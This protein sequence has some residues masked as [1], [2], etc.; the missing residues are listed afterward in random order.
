MLK[1][2]YFFGI[3]HQEV[4]PLKEDVIKEN[5]MDGKITEETLAWCQGMKEWLPL[6]DVLELQEAFGSLLEECMKPPPLPKAAPQKPVPPPLPKRACCAEPASREQ[7]PPPPK[8]DAP[9]GDEPEGLCPLDA[10][11]YRFVMWGFRPWRGKP[12]FVQDYVRKNPRRAVWVAG[13]SI[14]SLVLMFGLT[15]MVITTAVEDGNMP[16]QQQAYPQQSEPAQ[17]GGDWRQRYQIWQDQQR[18]TQRIL[19]DS[20]RYRRDSQDRRDETYRRANYDWY[21]DRND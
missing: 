10:A 6:C 2:R 16:V 19:D 17:G 21:T 3:D 20:Y 15:F 13:L 9:A 14:L 4:G 1:K 5:I 18:D 11:A 12:S 8:S 7:E